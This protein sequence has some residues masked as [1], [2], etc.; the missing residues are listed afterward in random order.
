MWGDIGNA[1]IKSPATF[2]EVVDP[3][4]EM[5]SLVYVATKGSYYREGYDKWEVSGFDKDEALS[6]EQPQG[7]MRAFVFVDEEVRV[8][9]CVLSQAK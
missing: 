9:W 2:H 7:G 4:S 1:M 6:V 5:C 3:L 8:T